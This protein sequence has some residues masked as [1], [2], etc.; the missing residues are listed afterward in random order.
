VL[1]RSPD[2]RVGGERR[3]L[4]GRLDEWP[5]AGIKLAAGAE[6]GWPRRVSFPSLAELEGALG[7]G[8]YPKLLLMDPAVADGFVRDWQPS[9]MAPERHVGYAVQWYALALTLLVIW[10]VVNLRPGDAPR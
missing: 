6:A 4:S 1:F 8:L 5:R 2:V 7:R 3:A 9:G 10:V